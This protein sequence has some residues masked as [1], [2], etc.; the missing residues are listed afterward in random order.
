MRSRA[1]IGLLVGLVL[2]AGSARAQD[3]V[4]LEEL[5][6]TEVRDA[7]RVGKTTVIVPT[8]GT[9][10]NGPHLVLGKHNLIVGFAAREIARR[11][12]DALVAPVVA[13]VPEG[14]IDPP[15]GQMW[16]PG[17]LSLPDAYFAKLLE[18]AA[19]SLRAHGFLDIVFIGDSGG[20]QAGAAAVAQALNRE[21]A[22]TAVRVHQIEAYYGANGFADWLRAQGE[23]SADIGTHAGI[24]D[25]S[26]LLAIHPEGVRRDRLAPGR[27]GDG[28]GVVGDP[29]RA[30]AEYGR[31]G[32]ELKIDAA[33]RAIRASRAER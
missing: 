27:P 20:N 5:T 16:A 13:Y 17:T 23:S 14:E 3:S 25:T 19:R 11:L 32:L 8:G 29:T 2:C 7:V 9:E 31:K 1:R 21:W 33:V 12:G 6:W 26:Q 28:S 10:Q 24:E 18:F 15:S 30:T 4:L 22:D